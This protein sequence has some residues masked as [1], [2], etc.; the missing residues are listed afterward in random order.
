MC[1]R[2]RPVETPTPTPKQVSSDCCPSSHTQYTTTGKPVPEETH[3]HTYPKVV[4][5]LI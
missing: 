5:K 1:R 4:V 3:V 2:T